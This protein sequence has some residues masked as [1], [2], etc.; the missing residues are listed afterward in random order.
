MHFATYAARAPFVPCKKFFALLGVFVHLPVSAAEADA[1]ARVLHKT[2]HIA[3][4][5][6]EKK[7]YLVRKFC[8]ILHS[9]FKVF[10]RAAQTGIFV[11]L[12]R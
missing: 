11:T 12:L 9:L 2:A 10:K 7:P 6:T 3:K 4:R 5:I 1:A 8:R